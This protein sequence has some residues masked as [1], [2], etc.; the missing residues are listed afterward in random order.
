MK[1]LWSKLF[2]WGV[3]K[4]YADEEYDE[5]FE[6]MYRHFP[7][8]YIVERESDAG[9]YIFAYESDEESTLI[10]VWRPGYHYRETSDPSALALANC[11]SVK[12]DES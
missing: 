4:Y 6:H 1:V 9:D 7:S 8:L 2:Y 5:W 12:Q 11:W 10:G 3:I